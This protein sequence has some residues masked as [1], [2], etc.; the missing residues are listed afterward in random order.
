MSTIPLSAAPQAP[1]QTEAATE[2]DNDPLDNAISSAMEDYVDKATDTIVNRDKPRDDSNDAPLPVV[3][4]NAWLDFK[5]HMDDPERVV[6]AREK[7]LDAA[8]KASVSRKADFAVDSLDYEASKQFAD[9]VKHRYLGKVAPEQFFDNCF[10]V[11]QAIAQDPDQWQVFAERRSKENPYGV[12]L[13]NPPAVPKP[14][15]DEHPNKKLDR[16]LD[17]SIDRAIDGGDRAGFKL[18]RERMDLLKKYFPNASYAN[19]MRMMLDADRDTWTDPIGGFARIAAMLGAPVMPYAQQAS[20]S[21]KAEDA[22]VRQLVNE[23]TAHLPQDDKTAMATLI[24]SPHWVSSGDNYADLSRAHQLVGIVDS[25]LGHKENYAEL[26]PL[27]MQ[28]L[29]HPKFKHI[30]HTAWETAA[31]AYEMAKTANAQWKKLNGPKK[32]KPRDGLDAVLDGAM[33]QHGWA[34]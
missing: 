27:I 8:L 1:I 7:G 5:E 29:A 6:P 9:V 18:T 34:A 23:T 10:Q 31:S 20:A 11:W 33:A 21:H 4:A 2:R 16:I 15:P 25:Y 14:D 24:D 30:G 17:R 19:A 22:A 32:S 12:R 3:E 13:E 26:R 28:T